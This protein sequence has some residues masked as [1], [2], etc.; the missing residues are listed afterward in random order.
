M[1]VRFYQFYLFIALSLTY[2]VTFLQNMVMTVAAKDVMRDLELS[3]DRMG[4]LGSSYLYAYG[5]SILFSGMLAAWLGPRRTITLMFLLSGV[6]GLVFASATSFPIACLGRILTGLGVSVV[7]ASAITFFSRWFRAGDF[8]MLS[9]IFFAIGGLG[10]FLGAAPMAILIARWGWRNG[11]FLVAA[12]TIFY[13]LLAHFTFRDWPSAEMEPSLGFSPVPRRPDSLTDLGKGMLILF[14]NREF[15]KLAAWFIGMSGMYLSFIGLWAA[16]YLRDVQHFSEARSG[17][18]VSLF[19]LGFII[20]NPVLS[21]YVEKRL[22]S[23]RL[24]LGMAGLLALASV[25]VLLA[26]GDRLSYASLVALALAIGF[27]LSAPNALVYAS[28]RNLFGSRLAG[29]ASGALASCCFASGALLQ[30][31]TGFILAWAA[32]R[33]IATGSSYQLAFLVYIPC[34]AIAA[35]AGFSLSPASDPGRISPLSWR[36]P[37]PGGGGQG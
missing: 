24:G 13:A 23:N 1:P 28:A 25:L 20:G 35:W 8:P 14:R 21:W 27:A 6:G 12:A 16:P 11:F 34:T 9:A 30:I 26:G 10:A 37:P 33:G 18:V 3:P 5:V 4:L 31:L 22:H 29:M 15:W 7:L 32:G 2:M 17:L 36:F 19:S